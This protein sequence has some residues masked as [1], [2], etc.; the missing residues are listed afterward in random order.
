MAN[1]N[2]SPSTRFQP[3]HKL[4]ANR[5]RRTV[6]E[7]IATA[8]LEKDGQKIAE[9]F[10]DCALDAE[11]KIETRLK[12][13]DLL[14]SYIWPKDNRDFEDS[15]DISFFKDLGLTLEEGLL[16]MKMVQERQVAASEEI[17]DYIMSLREKAKNND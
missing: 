3:G 16:F 7:G 4:S 8:L 10:R 11:E 14:F 9:L 15:I 5:K 1:P 17:V 6:A 13:G 12:A 2:P